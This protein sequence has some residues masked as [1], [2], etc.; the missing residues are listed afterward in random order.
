MKFDYIGSVFPDQG[1]A[2]TKVSYT[3]IPL[4]ERNVT[5]TIK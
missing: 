1:N 4:H 2:T 5:L 3:G